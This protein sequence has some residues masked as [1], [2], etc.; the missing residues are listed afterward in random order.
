MN[1]FHILG[2]YVDKP[3]KLENS[4]SP[5]YSEIFVRVK[6]NIQRPDDIN[7]HEVFPIIVWKGLSKQF[8][9]TMKEESLICV[10]GRIER[11]DNRYCLIAEL[12]ESCNEF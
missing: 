2:Y 3:K 9:E 7:C 12:I 10:R 1:S 5:K 4:T 6:P 11:I 8:L